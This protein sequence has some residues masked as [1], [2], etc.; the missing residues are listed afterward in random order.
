MRIAMMVH[1]YYL[2]D[3]RVRRYAE[4]LASEGH[5]V[6][7]EG[8][9][10]IGARQSLSADEPGSARP[11]AARNRRGRRDDLHPAAGHS[12]GYRVE[13]KNPRGGGLPDRGV[14]AVSS[15]AIV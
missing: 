5:T 9:R 12:H 13:H 3:A 1:A 4:L 15:Q 10:A 6:G 8:G 7:H 14:A 2:I 11:D